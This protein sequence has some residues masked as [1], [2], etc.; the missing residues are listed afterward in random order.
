[1]PCL[2]RQLQ[3]ERGMHDLTQYNRRRVQGIELCELGLR[4]SFIQ[5]AVPGLRTEEIIRMYQA[6]QGKRSSKGNM[7]AKDAKFLYNEHTTHQ[8]CLHGSILGRCMDILRRHPLADAVVLITAYREYLRL[9]H[10]GVAFID[11][12]RAWT[13]VQ[14]F[15]N[16]KLEL[17]RCSA[18]HAEYVDGYRMR[19][20]SCPI[21]FTL[22]KRELYQDAHLAL[23]ALAECSS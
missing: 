23:Q 14:A 20:N 18:C 13:M 22:R 12:N 3:K 2:T 9:I 10:P 6:V 1:M 21:C 5:E 19:S 16:G 7:P 4:P 17:I 11:A 8:L 15:R